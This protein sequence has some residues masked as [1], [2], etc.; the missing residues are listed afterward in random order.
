MISRYPDEVEAI[1]STY[2]IG[3]VRQTWW[4]L[5]WIDGCS[6]VGDLFV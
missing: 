5:Y 2:W 6:G 3:G 4:S 1:K